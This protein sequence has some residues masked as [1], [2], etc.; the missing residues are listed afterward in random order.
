MKIS[1]Y[2]LFSKSLHVKGA[3]SKDEHTIRFI[4]YSLSYSL[5][6]F[7]LIICFFFLFLILAFIYFTA[8][9]LSAA[10]HLF[11]GVCT[12]E[13]K[14]TKPV[15]WNIPS[16]R[17]PKRTTLTLSQNWNIQLDF[18]YSLFLFTS[19]EKFQLFSSNSK[20]GNI[21]TSSHPSRQTK[22]T[23]KKI[24]SLHNRFSPR[25]QGI[26]LESSYQSFAI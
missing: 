17:D 11:T 3:N 7:L 4:W 20:K 9:S 18:I 12:Q 26:K 14:E 5:S 15:V 6:T 8:R 21:L 1:T 23:N 10:V 25:V 13:N 2:C 24:S 16:F 19:F 22:W